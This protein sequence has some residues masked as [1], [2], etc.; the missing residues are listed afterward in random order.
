V[1][2]PPRPLAARVFE[3]RRRVPLSDTDAVGRLRLDAVARYL[4]DVASDDVA[5]AGWAAD[6]HFWVVRRTFLDVVAPFLGDEEVQ[7]ATWCSGV[8]AAAAARRTSLAGD[9][10]G[11]IEAESVWIHLDRDLRPA[12][13]GERFLAVYAPAADGRGVSTRFS[14]GAPPTDAASAPWPLRAT[15]VDRLGHVN[16]AAY[17]AAVEEAA[18]ELLDRRLRAA[19]EY[20]QPID[21]GERVQ[22][23]HANGGRGVW[24]VVDGTV[25]AAAIVDQHGSIETARATPGSSSADQS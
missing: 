15:D 9:R 16:N 10:G 12:R 25:R 7:L 13:F 20:R 4:Q 6:D 21:L 5:D 14:L 8:G 23:V 3:A 22:L 1:T 24:L 2:L 17:W 11:A 18:A 19:L